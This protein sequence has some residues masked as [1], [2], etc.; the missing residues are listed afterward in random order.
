MRLILSLG[1]LFALTPFTIDLY[2]PAFPQ[3]AADIGTTVSSMSL[4]VSIYFI[5]YAFGQILYG[6]FLDR[7]GRK[8]PLYI[9]LSIYIL[10]TIGCMNSHSL[11]QLIAFRLLSALGGSAASVGAMTMVRDF[12]PAKDVSKVIAML[13]LVLSTSPLLAPSIGSI[14]V[15]S[16]GW[17]LLFQILMGLAT[18]CLVLVILLPVGYKPDH[19]VKIR[20]KPILRTFASI[21]NQPQFRTYALST[22]FSFAGLFVYIAASPQVFMEGF[23]VTSKQFGGVFA[24][25]TGGMI[26]GGQLNRFFLKYMSS[27]KLYRTA[28]TV[29]SLIGVIF[30]IATF[31][32]V[33]I[34][35]TMAI[36][37]FF[38]LSAGLTSPNGSALAIA[39][40]TRNIGSAS[41]LFG[42]LELGL[43][44]F[45]SASTGLLHV[46][47]SVPMAVIMS[48]CAILGWLTLEKKLFD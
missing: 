13:M 26:L 7:Y 9:G 39:P 14:V 35:G 11:N 12:F 17:H 10:A 40:F 15:T 30:L 36:V 6:P 33:G 19:E 34:A 3:I 45:A 38:L 2:L 23:G 4:T 32:G 44:A 41:A 27:E 42:F 25:L 20:I 18:L 28:L 21:F 48:M 46:K 5:G 31:M 24:F 22:S 16:Y 47:G 29:Q 43:G 8:P 37:F 1:I